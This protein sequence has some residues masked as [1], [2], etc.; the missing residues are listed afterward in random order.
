MDSFK[1]RI[2]CCLYT[3]SSGKETEIQFEVSSIFD[4]YL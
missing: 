4:I 3:L 1:Q 2:S